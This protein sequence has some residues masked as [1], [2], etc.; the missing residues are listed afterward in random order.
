MESKAHTNPRIDLEFEV[1]SP[2]QEGII[3]KT[4]QRPDKSYF[5]E[6]QELENFIN[7]GRLVQKLLPKQADIDKISKIIQQKILKG[8]H[9]PATIKQIQAE[10]LVSSYFKDIYLYLPQNKL[11]S[12]KTAIKKIKALA[13]KYI[14]RFIII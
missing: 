6:M 1:N 14:I 3:Y 8:T 11:P 7:M 4:Y 5:Q 13:E 9:L 12:N 2:Y 10:Y